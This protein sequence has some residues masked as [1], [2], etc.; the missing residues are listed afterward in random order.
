MSFLK[1]C[2]KTWARMRR[3]A[4]EKCVAQIDLAG[5]SYAITHAASAKWNCARKRMRQ[6]GAAALSL[7]C[8]RGVPTHNL[9]QPKMQHSQSQPPPLGKVFF[10]IYDSRQLDAAMT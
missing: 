5:A 7:R 6:D 9:P 4:L 1:L 10:E 8:H 2:V 3:E